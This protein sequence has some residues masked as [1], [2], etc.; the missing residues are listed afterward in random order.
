MIVDYIDAHRDKLGVEPICRVLTDAGTKIAPSTYYAFRTRP[1][2]ARSLSDAATTVLIAKLHEENYG[3]YGAPKVHA[4]LRRQGQPVARCTVQR[5]MRQAGLRGISRA[6]GPRTTIPGSG[7]D[8]RPDLVDRAFRAAAPDR[9]WV[10]DITYCRTFAGWVYAAFVIDVFSRRV[11]GW[12]LSTSLRP[13][14]RS[15]PSRW[16]SGPASTPD[17]D[18]SSLFTTRTRAFSTSR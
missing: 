18:H 1:P 10:A 9:L 2:S 12:Q 11:V 4:E 5:L 16:A 17:S 13:T 3:V 8:T 6:K 15:T 14:L 7:P